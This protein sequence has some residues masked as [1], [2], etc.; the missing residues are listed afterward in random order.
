MNIIQI[1]LHILPREIDELDRI[2]DHLHRSSFFLE[3][4]DKIN[5]DITL[6]L[7]DQFTNWDKSLLPK[8]FFITAPNSS[9]GFAFSK[10]LL[11]TFKYIFFCKR[12]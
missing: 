3:K 2:C 5:L 6:N 10:V 9:K 8:E 1:L 4:N 11:K 12:F 7:S